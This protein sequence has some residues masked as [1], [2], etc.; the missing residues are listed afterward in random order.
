MAEQKQNNANIF[1]KLFIALMFFI[2]FLVFMYPFI[3]NGVNNYVAQKE[4]NAVNQ[5]NQSNQKASAKKLEKLI[6][7]NKQKSK[8]NQQLGISPVK[9]ILG[10]TLENV[11]KESR[12]YYQKHS[13]GSIFIPKISLSLPV[14]DTTTDSLLYKGITLL[15]GSSY[16]VGGKSTHTVLMGHS[17]LPNQELFT[18]LHELKKGDKFFLKV[19]GKRLAYQVI[20]IKVVLPTDLSDITIQNNQDLATLVTCTPYM[21]NTHRLLVTGK[22]VTLDKG[23]FDKQEKRQCHIKENICFV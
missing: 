3:A 6:K 20:R 10:Q 16:P 23:S 17:G 13:L 5:L 19:Y 21:V 18:H 2:G 15:P 7:K 8:K 14:F 22:R 11:P 4:L 12:E 9:N 1:L